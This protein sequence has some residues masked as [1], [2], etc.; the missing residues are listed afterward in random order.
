MGRA[1]VFYRYADTVNLGRSVLIVGPGDD[2][3][4]ATF[5]SARADT[6]TLGP[7]TGPCEDIPHISACLE[8][9]TEGS[10]STIWAA[11]VLEHSRNPGLFLDRCYQLLEPG[12]NLFIAVPPLKHQI[13]SGHVTLWNMG[14]LWYHLILAGFDVTNGWYAT[15]HYNIFAHVR[16]LDYRIDLPLQHDRPDVDTL[17]HLGLWPKGH[18]LHHG[19]NGC[20]KIKPSF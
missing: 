14:L 2:V 1:A 5:F 3:D 9:V 17:N 7:G 15:H 18:D 11:H 8:D 4:D 20:I 10:Y 12:G 6:T 16:R 13:V 19:F